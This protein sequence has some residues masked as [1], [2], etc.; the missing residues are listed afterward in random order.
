MAPYMGALV[1]AV[2]A[3][4]STNNALHY[5]PGDDSLPTTPGAQDLFS[6][7]EGTQVSDFIISIGTFGGSSRLVESARLVSC[8]HATVGQARWPA[9][10]ITGRGAG[11]LR[12]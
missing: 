8:L 9:P 5:E 11:R 10:L 12:A 3:A 6:G 7:G 1:P 4:S 2:T